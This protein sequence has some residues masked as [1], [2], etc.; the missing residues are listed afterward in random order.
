MPGALELHAVPG[1]EHG[2]LVAAGDRVAGAGGVAALIGEEH[3]AGRFDDRAAAGPR[4]AGLGRAPGSG[5]VVA[6]SRGRVGDTVRGALRGTAAGADRFVGVA[7][8]R[9]VAARIRAAVQK[10]AGV[11]CGVAVRWPGCGVAAPAWPVGSRRA[12]SVPAAVRVPRAARDLPA[13]RGAG[14]P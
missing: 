8:S 11:A 14:M 12:S 10:A 3:P 7:R 13:G 5:L 2:A 4:A 1:R 9:G 6:G